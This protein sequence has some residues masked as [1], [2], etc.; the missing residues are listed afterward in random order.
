MIAASA[1]LRL[2]AMSLF[3]VLCATSAMAQ[4]VPFVREVKL[5]V[6]AHD[7]P[8]LWSGF[9]LEQ[10]IGV[11]G[12]VILS[13]EVAF[14]GGHLRPALGGTYTI[15]T[16]D[17]GVTSKAYA[18][19]RWMFEAQNGLF[20]SLGIGAAIHDGLLDSGD[21]NRKWLGRRALFHFPLELGWRFDARQSISIYFDHISNG[22][23]TKFNEGLDT[24]GLR[25][26]YRF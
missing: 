4:S 22:Y 1:I 12:E 17:R 2:I 19:V 18:D 7:V 13:P 24:L 26:G 16:R 3:V 9:R 14:L 23:T 6:V 20:L 8:G 5:G 11:N 15:P 25:Y 10:G 21:V